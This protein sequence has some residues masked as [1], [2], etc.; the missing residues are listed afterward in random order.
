MAYV[1]QRQDVS[2]LH[3]E[4]SMPVTIESAELLLGD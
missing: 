4:A 1:W 3:I 2:Q